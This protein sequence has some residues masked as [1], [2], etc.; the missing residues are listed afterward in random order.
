MDQEI[1]ETYPER[2]SNPQLTR[3]P[4]RPLYPLRYVRTYLVQMG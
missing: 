3:S 2:D 1:G 4:N